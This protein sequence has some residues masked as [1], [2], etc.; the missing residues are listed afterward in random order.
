MSK[1]QL[2]IPV[3]AIGLAA[4]FLIVSAMVLL[5]RHP[6][7]IQRKLRVGALLLSLTAVASCG[8]ETIT[9]YDPAM[10]NY[11]E[12]EQSYGGTI[13]ID[14]NETQ[15]LSGAIHDREGE[16]FS[17]LLSSDSGEEMAREDIAALDG[18][19]DEN[20]EEFEIT[21]P[22]SLTAGS[23]TLDLYASAADA[24]PEYASSTFTLEVQ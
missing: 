8:E 18:A 10:P 24:Q 22:T 7:W 12:L 1:N 19:F 5:T 13:A 14:L 17:Y 3:L 16:A 9:C 21:L 6:K 20:V 2:P 23:Y 11:F 4:A 15:T